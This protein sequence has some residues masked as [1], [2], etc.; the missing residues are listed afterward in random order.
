MHV[1]CGLALPCP[2]AC[3]VNNTPA[4]AMRPA[5]D[6]CLSWTSVV[7]RTLKKALDASKQGKLLWHYIGATGAGGRS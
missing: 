5:L 6:I 1:K 2:R 7:V 4:A 3:Q